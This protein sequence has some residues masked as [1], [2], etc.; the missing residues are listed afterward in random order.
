M[1]NSI[2]AAIAIA[3]F[4]GVAFSQ[5][6][7]I[8]TTGTGAVT[9]TGTVGSTVARQAMSASLSAQL[10]F[11]TI[12]VGNGV[13]TYQIP[14]STIPTTTPWTPVAA[15]Q[16]KTGV[17]A[18]TPGTAMVVSVTGTSSTLEGTGYSLVIPATVSLAGPAG[19]T[20][21][22]TVAAPTLARS[23]NYKAIAAN[24]TAARTATGFTA[25]ELTT[26]QFFDMFSVGGTLAIGASQRTGAYTGS[27]P[28]EIAY[29]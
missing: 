13:G 12:T 8:I 5:T 6:L 22:V 15:T 24:L 26:D 2:K 19:A 4:A 3:V 16:V 9:V 29:Q 7:P 27:L 14:A 28:I 17:V 18:T 23:L 11:G 1:R 21:T 10:D 20:M 25:S